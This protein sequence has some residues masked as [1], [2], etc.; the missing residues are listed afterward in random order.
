ME[1]LP[2]YKVVSSA[3]R[4][5]ASGRGMPDPALQLLLGAGEFEMQWEAPP[6]DSPPSEPMLRMSTRAVTGFATNNREPSWLTRM[7]AR[8]PSPATTPQP[9]NAA[10]ARQPVDPGSWVSAPVTASL[11]KPLIE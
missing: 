11:A 5:R 8:P 9:L 2:T 10:A 6:D 7:E 4:A 3:D 1:R